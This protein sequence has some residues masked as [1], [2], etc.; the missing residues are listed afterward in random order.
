MNSL[1]AAA[2]VPA[3]EQPLD[4]TAATCPHC[5][6]MLYVPTTL[7]DGTT[8]CTPCASKWAPSASAAF[9]AQVGADIGFG[10]NVNRVLSQ[11]LTKCFPSAVTAAALRQEGT[12][13]FKRGDVLAAE[14]SYGRSVDVCPHDPTTMSNRS[15]ARFK[16]G[17]AAGALAD[18]EAAAALAPS[19]PKAMFR[20]GQALA[21]MGQ[22]CAA[23]TAFARSLA[24][25]HD[26]DRERRQPN[27]PQHTSDCIA[28]RKTLAG[29][30]EAALKADDA[31]AA[32][33]AAFENLG[34]DDDEAAAVQLPGD[35][36]A[37][38]PTVAL[39]SARE[40]L[41]CSLCFQLL[42]R[43]T[44]LACGH[45]TC[46]PCL[47]RILDH[48]FDREPVSHTHAPL[49]ICIYPAQPAKVGRSTNSYPHTVLSSCAQ[50]VGPS[51]DRS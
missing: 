5:R 9:D 41:D 31:S 43:P 39:Q 25:Q 1:R 44:T 47:T 46:T 7:L 11:V 42:F 20:Q 40:D 16:L 38:A 8:V 29:A 6:G 22:P 4:I 10:T 14:A 24:L 2:T 37:A 30:L 23:S 35:A 48:A 34:G 12:T 19:W 36:G 15:A 50:C 32:L 26:A 13:H 3:E 21:L 27:G 18:A 33:R 28:T 17:D 51:S 45:V 49:H